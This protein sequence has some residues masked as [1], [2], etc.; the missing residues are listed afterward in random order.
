MPKVSVILPAYNGE[1]F[2]AGA[3]DSALNQ[4]RKDF[5]II[6]V[7]DGSTDRT[8]EIISK[9][10]QAI[11]VISQANAGIAAARN[12]AINNSKGEYLAFLDQDDI[13]LEDKLEK[14]MEIFD[15]DK[16]VGMVYSDT[17]VITD[18]NVELKN[19]DLK[20]P[21]RGM[22][23]E[24]LLMNNFIATSA[25]VTKKECFDRVGLFDNSLSPCLDYDRWLY[26]ATLY[27]VD[28][29]DKPLVRFRDHIS[30]FRK[31]EIFTIGKIID[32]LTRYAD[33]HPDVKKSMGNKIDK[34]IAYYRVTLGRRFLTKG[35]FLEAFSNFAAAIKLSK[36]FFPVLLIAW[37]MVFDLTKN[38]IKNIQRY[39]KIR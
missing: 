4:T 25:V 38:S 10:G 21:Y 32:T 33:N 1:K 11:R 14:Q 3:I 8:A 15:K 17:F 39:I 2:I 23:I 20:K 22:I 28:Y 37:F 7:N 35:D 19:F 34:K 9:Y 31:N 27:K 26:I 29:V 5:E 30:T 16:D 24:E 12:A 13:W 36:S 18:G 6:V